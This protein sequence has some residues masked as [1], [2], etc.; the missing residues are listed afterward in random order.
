[1]SLRLWEKAVN[2]LVSGKVNTK[3]LE[4]NGNEGLIHV[5]VALSATDATR[6]VYI[7]TRPVILKAVSR[8]H[9]TASTSGTLQLEKC[10]GTTAPGSG[11]VLLTAT[12]SLAGAANTVVS[13]TVLATPDTI[14]LA[15]GDRLG[16]VIAGTMT[17]LVGG[18]ATITLAPA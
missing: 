10:T 8:T 18:I 16:I 11:T 2:I 1:M 17:S 13:G 12:V 9:T 4:V 15:T 6:N 3:R 7:A 5:P 14:K